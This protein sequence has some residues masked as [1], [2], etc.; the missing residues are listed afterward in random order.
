M[1]ELLLGFFQYYGEFDY[2]HSVICPLLGSKCDKHL[3]TYLDKKST[4]PEDME[5]Y[6]THL[7][8][9]N[10]EFFR[11]DSAMCV[12]DPFVLS[13]NITRAVPVLTL[14]SFKEYCK[15]SESYVKLHFAN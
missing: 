14:R 8:G 12:Q 2:M 4:F 11:V 1:Y 7:Q 13:Y 3:F 6:V 5:P 10:P 15:K 9:V